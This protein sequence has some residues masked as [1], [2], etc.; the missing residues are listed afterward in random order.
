MQRA[1]GFTLVELMIVLAIIG[2]LA[3][4]AAHNYTRHAFRSRRAEAQQMLMAIAQSQERWHA[5][6]HHYAGD[7][8]KLGYA[9]PAMSPHGNYEVVLSATDEHYLAT[10]KPVGRQAADACG[11]LSLDNAGRKLPDKTD[12]AANTNGNCW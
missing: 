5:I 8:V 3:A 7:P 10:A 6:H 4:F 11:N 2:T 9:N 1:Q 12:A